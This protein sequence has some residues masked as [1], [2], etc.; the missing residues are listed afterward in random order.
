LTSQRVLLWD[1][2]V[3]VRDVGGL[4]T[5]DGQDTR[6]GSIV[7]ADQ[8]ADLTDD[9]WRALDEYGVRVAIDLRGEYEVADDPPRDVPIRVVRITISPREAPAAFEWPSIGEAYRA[10]LGHF[11][12]QFAAAIETIGREDGPV[13]IHC[14]GGRDRT[15]LAVALLLRLARVASE[16]IAADH[17][18]SDESFAPYHD[19]W[20][21]EAPDEHEHA[22]R[23]RIALPAGR[24]MADVLGEVEERYGGP[25]EYLLGG[26]ATPAGL[27]RAVRRLRHH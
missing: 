11:R 18:I 10:L 3:N 13:V 15:G 16:T 6:F 5:E 19:A 20:F 26:G 24:T 14:A 17:A 23:R 21:A 8:I 2:C 25:R 22:R 27:G 12:P 1:G 4:P 7:R 9:G